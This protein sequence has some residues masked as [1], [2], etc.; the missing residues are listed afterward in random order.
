MPSTAMLGVIASTAALSMLIIT[1]NATLQNDI[2][3]AAMTRTGMLRQ[4]AK[5]LIISFLNT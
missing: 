2:D 1:G 5:I 4:T 3:I